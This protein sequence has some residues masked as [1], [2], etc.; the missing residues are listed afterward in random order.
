MTEPPPR[1]RMV[2]LPTAGSDDGRTTPARPETAQPA[3]PRA[4]APHAP[5][6]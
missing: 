1:K 4:Q 5:G 6:P 3:P 2:R